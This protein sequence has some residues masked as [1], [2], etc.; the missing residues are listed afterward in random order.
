MLEW[1]GSKCNISKKIQWFKSLPHGNG[2]Q[3]ARNTKS[4]WVFITN[5]AVDQNIVVN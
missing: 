3:G 2:G 4:S 5:L 1:N